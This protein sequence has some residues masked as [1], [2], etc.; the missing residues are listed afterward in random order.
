LQGNNVEIKR[1]KR[2][3]GAVWISIN[4]WFRED[5]QW[6][7]TWEN[8]ILI[9]KSFLSTLGQKWVFDERMS[10]FLRLK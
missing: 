6:G 10:Q 1:L 7:G 3:K 2:I 8:L 4:Q 9:F 5:Q